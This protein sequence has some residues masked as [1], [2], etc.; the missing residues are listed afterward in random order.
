MSMAG[1]WSER[2]TEARDSSPSTSGLYALVPRAE[3]EVRCQAHSGV[4]AVEVSALWGSDISGDY[5]A[6]VNRRRPPLSFGAR[7]LQSQPSGTRASSSSALLSSI[8]DALRSLDEAITAED[9]PEDFT[10]HARPLFAEEARGGP[11]SSLALI[12]NR[13]LVTGAAWQFSS[14]P[15]EEG[16]MRR[17][18]LRRLSRLEPGTRWL[19]SALKACIDERKCSAFRFIALTNRRPTKCVSGHMLS[20][21]NELSHPS[22]EMVAFAFLFGRVMQSNERYTCRCALHRWHHASKREADKCHLRSSS[23]Q[24]HNN[25]TSCSTPGGVRR[26]VASIEHSLGQRQSIS[27]Q[28]AAAE[29]ENRWLRRAVHL[30]RLVQ[31]SL[32][33]VA[34]SLQQSKADAF[35]TLKLNAIWPCVTKRLS[36]PTVIRHRPVAGSSQAAM[37]H[38]AQSHLIGAR[39]IGSVLAQVQ[40]QFASMAWRRLIDHCTHRCYHE[41]YG[42]MPDGVVEFRSGQRE[43]WRNLAREES[44]D[45]HDTGLNSLTTLRSSHAPC[46]WVCCGPHI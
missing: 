34:L 28:L 43:A 11:R 10:A 39:W 26:V 31:R 9:E 4:A 40:S 5:F 45:L 22:T 3:S 30:E 35:R 21:Y 2:C 38:A 44:F 12:D 20:G 41:R 13:A 16:K 32:I 46:K 6:G 42:M 8:D 36:F 1:L 19:Y 37:E 27:G 23:A 29:A 18:R 14:T 17:D 15:A 33:Q 25:E 24:L 7:S